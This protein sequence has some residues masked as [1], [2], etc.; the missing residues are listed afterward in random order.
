M[1][2]YIRRSESIINNLLEEVE[3][4]TSRV[5]HIKLTY[6]KTSNNRLRERLINENKT[7]LERLNEIFSM[8]ELIEKRT[9]EKL[10]LSSLLVEKCRR[11][12]SEINLSRHLFFL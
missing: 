3:S 10:S 9:A 6:M 4:L 1:K 8:A 7:L 2:L 11:T 5:K 12:V